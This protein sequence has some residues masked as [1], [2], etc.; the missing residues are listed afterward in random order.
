MQYTSMLTVGKLT[1]FSD[2]KSYFFL[3]IFEL[4]AVGFE[5]R[6][7]NLCFGVQNKKLMYTLQTHLNNIEVGYGVL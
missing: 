6:T 1:L 3:M 2:E 4:S 5:T 7:N